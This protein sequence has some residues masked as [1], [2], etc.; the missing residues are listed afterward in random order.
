MKILVTGATGFIGW[1]LAGRLLSEGHEVS[2]LVRKSSKKQ[3]L[4][5]SGVLT[6]ES[7][8]TDL[9]GFKKAL[10]AVSPDV[11]YHCAAR[12]WDSDEEALFRDNAQG[13]LTVCRGCL[14]GKVNRLIYLSSVAVVSGNKEVPLTD[15][16]PYK[17]SDAYGR[18]KIEAEKAA[19][20]Y[21]N[22]GLDVSIIRPCMVYGEDE[23]HAMDRII[24]SVKARRIPILNI[25]KKEARLALVHVENVVD[26]LVLSLYGKASLSG[27]FI[28]ADAEVITIRKFLEILSDELGAGPPFVVPEWLTDIATLIPGVRARIDRIFKD[29]VYDISRARQ[30]LGYDPVITTEEGLRRTVRYWKNNT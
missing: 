9:A 14:E 23:P 29:R 30:L 5:D 10:R 16:M 8:I 26:A 4:I 15:D 2:A 21:R 22:K 20:E 7:D 24:R 3:K 13:T 18:S 1:K 6:V 19:F 17:A 27:T 12:V 28:I 25:R 11:V